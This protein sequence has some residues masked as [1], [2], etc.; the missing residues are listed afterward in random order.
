MKIRIL[1]YALACA[2]M[3]GVSACNT[4]PKEA[5]SGLSPA[6][7]TSIATDAYIFGYPMV[8]VDM[9]RRISTNVEKDAGMRGPMGQF[10]NS[11][12]YPNAAYR[13][14]TAPNA[15]TLYSQGWLDLS[16]EPYVFSIPDEKGRYFL[17]PILDAW[18]TVFQVPGKRTT[19]TR[20]QKYLITGPGWSGTVPG[21]LTQYKSATNLVWILGRTYCT[22]TTQDYAEVH[23]IQDQY[24]LVPLSSY[25]KPYTP[26]AGMVDPSIDMKTPVRDQ[27]NNMD[28]NAYFNRLAS[29][30]KDNPPTAEDAPMVA[31]MAKIG[32]VPGQ[33]FDSSKL[34]PAVFTALQSVPK[35]AFGKIMANM[36]DI[37]TIINGWIF[38]TKTGIYG[39]DYL[40]RATVTAVGLGANRPQDAI[41]PTS[42]VGADGKAYDGANKY[43]IHFDKGQM[44]PADGFWSLTMYD[45]GYFFV[46]NPLNRYNLSSRNKYVPNA[47]GSVDMY[48]QADSPGKAKEA[49]WLPAPKGRFIL[50]LRLYW[51]KTTPPSI[52]DG[53]WKPPAVTP[54]P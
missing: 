20:A 27:V 47:D 28:L 23:A 26:P 10:S 4:G 39:T 25:G 37:G 1:S 9:T 53:T 38:T 35:D 43:V 11:R 48:L 2:A 46:D 42:E 15:D 5:I 12:T 31:R 16:K 50:M 54:A 32:L 8:T 30:M 52:I 17:M 36:K 24:K 19:G 18:T 6:E 21:G 34:D 14:I 7:A 29:L 3:L 51:P 45:A 13:D 49:N 41:Y 40:A 22:G 44:P 33:P